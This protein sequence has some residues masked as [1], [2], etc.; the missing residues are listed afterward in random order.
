MP[1]SWYPSA[2]VDRGSAAGYA[3][4]TAS[5]VSC[6]VHYTVGTDSRGLIRDQGLAQFLVARD[7]TVWQFA[8]ANAVCYQA[9]YP[10]NGRGPGIEVEYLPGQD[11]AMF[12]AEARA[13]C[14]TLVR[15]LNSEWGIPLDYYD[16]PDVRVAAHAGFISHRSVVE[17]ADP[18]TD[19]WDPSDWA[20]MVAPSPAPVPPLPIPVFSE[21]EGPMNSVVAPDGTVYLFVLGLDSS[22]FVNVQN[23]KTKAWSGFQA[24][25][26]IVG[27]P[28]PSKQL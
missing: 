7:G 18:H 21:E 12:T 8:E 6:V 15:W 20:L 23:P 17:D 5:M 19:Y 11:Q 4:G 13:A 25:G 1:E 10:Y 28:K 9:G 27:S 22:V 26:G 24:L 2:T 3:H 14:G 16:N